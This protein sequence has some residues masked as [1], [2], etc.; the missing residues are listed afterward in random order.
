MMVKA[1]LREFERRLT[2]RWGAMLI[3]SAVLQVT[4][5]A[6]MLVIIAR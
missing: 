6:V 2:L 1:D 3:A 5:V 4:I